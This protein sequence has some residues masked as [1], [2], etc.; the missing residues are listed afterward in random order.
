MDDT[1]RAELATQ[2]AALLELVAV[3]R[4]VVEV[5]AGFLDDIR[6]RV[7]LKPAVAGQIVTAL[8]KWQAAQVRLAAIERT[9][10]RLPPAQS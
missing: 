4:Q 8:Q 2:R 3:N 5:L 6:G 10:Y 7:N 1:T 9:L